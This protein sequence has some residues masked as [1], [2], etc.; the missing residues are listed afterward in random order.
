MSVWADV[1]FLPNGIL[2]FLDYKV[3]VIPAVVGEQAWIKT[4]R[5]RRDFRI[6]VFEREI[7]CVSWKRQ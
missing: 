2:Q 4:E 5:Y 7:L 3:Q 1:W 6:G